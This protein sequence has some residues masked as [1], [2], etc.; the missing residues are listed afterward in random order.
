MC[1]Y[2]AERMT[3]LERAAGNSAPTPLGLIHTS[4]GGTIAEMWVPNATLY[5]ADLGCKNV[6]GGPPHQRDDYL[7]GALYNGMVMPWANTSLS[8][9]LWRRPACEM[10]CPSF[11]GAR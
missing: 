11:L 5:D 3:D 9:V 1:W 7:N 8:G 2:F 6:T 4:W 10:K